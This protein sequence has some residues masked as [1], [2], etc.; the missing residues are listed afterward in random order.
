MKDRSYVDEWLRRARSNIAR[1]ELGKV[2]DDIL[3]EDLCFDCQQAV[4][5][6]LKALLVHIGVDF[7]WTHSIARLAELI[8]NADVDMPGFAKD[9]VILTAYAVNTRYPGSQEPVDEVEYKEALK[10]AEMV[11][12]WVEGKIQESR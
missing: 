11:C 9:S 1:A 4:E 8:E 2:S 10:L 3:Y 5:K 6:S 7:P 12:R